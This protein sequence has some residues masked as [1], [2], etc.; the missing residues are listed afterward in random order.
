MYKNNF[1]LTILRDGEPV[2]EL[3]GKVYLPFNTEYSIRLKNRHDKRALANVSIDGRAATSLGSLIIPPKSSVTLERF[4]DH[5]LIEGCRFK[6]VSLDHPEVDDPSDS[7]NGIVRVEFYLER[8]IKINYDPKPWVPQIDRP[9]KPW[10]PWRR[11]DIK[12]IYEP[13]ATDSTA[14][15]AVGNHTYTYCSSLFKSSGPSSLK[16]ATVGGDYSNQH[17]QW[18]ENFPTETIPTIIN[19][20]IYSS[21]DQNEVNKTYLASYCTRCGRRRRLNN[22]YCA[23]CG[24]K[25]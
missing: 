20:K 6:F 16:G 9:W 1:V 3:G 10:K 7:N 25:Y 17:F 4:L 2:K 21:A 14:D 19:L 5:S 24:K 13:E 22:V 11:E 8:N 15:S 12:W 23:S 18:G